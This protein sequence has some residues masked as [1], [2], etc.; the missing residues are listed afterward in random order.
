MSDPTKV[1][2]AVVMTPDQFPEYAS[3]ADWQRFSDWC[4]EKFE[5]YTYK[6]PSR[7]RQGLPGVITFG[8]ESNVSGGVGQNA[9]FQDY[10]MESEGFIIG[11]EMAWT[12]HGVIVF[13][14]MLLKEI[15]KAKSTLKPLFPNHTPQIIVR[16][17]QV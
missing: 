10:G 6:N 3:D 16:G 1:Y 2:V 8:Y 9:T 5:K 4:Y 17:N 15:E 7:S 13:N 12:W 14:E 11:Y